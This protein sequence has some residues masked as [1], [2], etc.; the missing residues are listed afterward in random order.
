M[1]GRTPGSVLATSLA[2]RIAAPNSTY[3]TDGTRR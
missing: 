3:D 1:P 2:Y